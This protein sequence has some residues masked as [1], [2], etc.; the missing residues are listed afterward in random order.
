MSLVSTW[1]KSGPGCGKSECKAPMAEASL[2]WLGKDK[3]QCAWN[4]LGRAV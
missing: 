2:P 3:G 4:R 1:E